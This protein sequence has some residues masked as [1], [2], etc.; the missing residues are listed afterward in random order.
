MRNVEVTRFFCYNG[1]FLSLVKD[2]VG[3]S[4]NNY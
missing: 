4:Q 2:A 1:A 3:R